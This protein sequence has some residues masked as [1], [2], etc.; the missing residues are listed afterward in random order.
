MTENHLE[1]TMK[2]YRFAA[3]DFLKYDNV[4]LFYFQNMEDVV[5]D[6]NNYADYTH[7]NPRINRYMTECFSDG[8]H[9]VTSIEEFD[10]ELEKMRSIIAE[11]DFEELFSVEY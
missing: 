3:E 2:Q 4:R 10:E 1:A 9:E 7:Y 8:T 5:T 11:F 6:L